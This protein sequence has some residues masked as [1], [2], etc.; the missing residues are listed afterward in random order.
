M[1]KKKPDESFEA[2]D[3]ELKKDMSFTQ[4]L[5]L[6]V[7]AQIGSGWLFGVLAAAGMAGPAAIIS[8]IIASVLIFLISLTYLEIGAMLPRSG[9]I[10]RY[11]YLTHGSLSG[12]IIGWAYW[13]SVVAIPALESVAALTYI[14]GKWPALGL[15]TKEGGV[16]MLSWPIGIL[17]GVALMVLFFCLNYFG[18][19]LLAESNKWVTYWKIALP[20]LT[21]IFLFFILDGSNFSDF[22]GFAPLGWSGVFHAIPMTGIVFSLLGFRQALDY[23]GESKNPGKDVP[24]AT[25][26]SILIPTIIYALLQVA[27]IGAIS[28]SSMGLD[29]GSWSLLTSGGWAD[30]PLFHALESA[31]VGIMAAFGVFLLIDA[32]VSPLATGWGYLGTGSRTGYGL[33]IHR[34]IPKIFSKNNKHGIPWVPLVLSAIVGCVFFVPAPSWYKL[35]GFISSAAVLTYL[36][37]GI[38]L[39]ILRKTA[40]K[41]KRPFVLKGHHF[42]SLVS[43]LAAAIVLYWSGFETLTNVFTITL[44]GLP[45]YTAYDARIRGWISKTS[46]VLLSVVFLAALLFISISSG[47][48]LNNE[49]HE[50]VLVKKHPALVESV[51]KMVKEYPKVANEVNENSAL[52]AI[53]EKNPKVIEHP[54][55][56][57][58]LREHPEMMK[59][60]EQHPKIFKM[61][62]LHPIIVKAVFANPDID[63]SGLWTF[64][65]Y[66]LSF[67]VL[68]VLFF[69]ILRW[70]SDKEGRKHV[71]ATWWLVFLMLATMLV[72]CFS[73]Y[74]PFRE[75]S[76]FVFPIS[77]FIEIGVGIIAYFIGINTG[78]E[79][80]E[81]K[82]IVAT[83]GQ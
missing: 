25:F 45:I 46:S 35:V 17:A 66:F 41:L 42:W 7:S 76:P 11:T 26:G 48:V 13:I 34:S 49:I 16:D 51:R 37:G 60:I 23:G 24:R 8:W 81:I 21:F 72:S 14:G 65:L 75:I 2:A 55:S 1:N 31:N 44:I 33:S 29:P 22:G 61:D 82:A 15:L 59:T 38:G 56:D 40:P 57:K 58:M 4:L 39:P 78:F 67:G 68:I 30:G 83:E 18:S 5:L 54:E 6:G 20:T 52:F 64:G 50:D 63:T 12:W 80:E 3:K 79:T 74:G 10:V 47:W 9:G 69:V 27:F 43:F 62:V 73:Y 71:D 19:K 77:T 28:W 32:A 70:V 53:A 36:M